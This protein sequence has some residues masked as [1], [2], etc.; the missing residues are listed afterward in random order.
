MFKSWR[1][2][3]ELS[4]KLVYF[5]A[6]CNMKRGYVAIVTVSDACS[7]CTEQGGT[8]FLLAMH[9]DVMKW[10]YTFIVLHFSIGTILK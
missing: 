9:G 1:D 10:C 8:L 2:L 6:S 7:S 5:R 4:E 3:L